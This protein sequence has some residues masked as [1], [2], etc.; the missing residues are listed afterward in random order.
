M[1]ASF[2][3]RTVKHAYAPPYESHFESVFEKN[4]KLPDYQ[5]ALNQQSNPY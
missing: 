2:A 5:G 3:E 1:R 4:I